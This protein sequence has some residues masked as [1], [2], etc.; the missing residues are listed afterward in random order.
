MILPAGRPIPVMLGDPPSGS[1]R[2]FV[3]SPPIVLV[4]VA[5]DDRPHNGDTYT[6]LIDT[7]ADVTVIDQAVAHRIGAALVGNGISRGFGGMRSGVKRTRITITFAAANLVFEEPAAG[8]LDFRVAGLT[9]DLVL[10][11]AFLRY[12]R[13]TLDGPNGD[14]RLEWLG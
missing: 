10:G 2:D 13:L 14:Y 3:G 8:V 12:C 5:A 9:F 11:R 7:G 4:H 6:A 1:A